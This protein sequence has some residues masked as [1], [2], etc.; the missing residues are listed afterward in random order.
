[1]ACKNPQWTRQGVG[2]ALIHLPAVGSLGGEN[3]WKG[4]T[5]SPGLGPPAPNT[6][7]AHA[8]ASG[9]KAEN[10]WFPDSSEV[11]KRQV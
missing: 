11:A 4:V 1:M 9:S 2:P 8:Q 7:L 6:G 10:N 5:T 3:R